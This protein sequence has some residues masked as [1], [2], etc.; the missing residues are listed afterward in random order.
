MDKIKSPCRD[1]GA[2]DVKNRDCKL[3]M[4]YR[5]E[6]KFESLYAISSCRDRLDATSSWIRFRR[7]LGLGEKFAIRE[8]ME[9]FNDEALRDCSPI[10]EKRKSG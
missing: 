1:G 8:R 9:T 4:S 3:S 6:M 2:V 5:T 10:N 7:F